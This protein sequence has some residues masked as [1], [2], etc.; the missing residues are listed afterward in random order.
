MSSLSPEHLNQLADLKEQLEGAQILQFPE[1]QPQETN[2]PV[3]LT[4]RSR[5]VGRD[6]G[7]P[8]QQSVDP[9]MAAPS[10]VDVVL[11]ESAKPAVSTRVRGGAHRP[12]GAPEPSTP[13]QKPKS[14][15]ALALNDLLTVDRL[16]RGHRPD[17]TMLSKYER[18]Q[19]M[20]HEV[21]I[22]RGLG[23]L[24]AERGLVELD[25]NNRAHR[26]NGQ[27]MSNKELS[28]LVSATKYDRAGEEAAAALDDEPVSDDQ[29]SDRLADVATRADQAPVDPGAEADPARELTE[30]VDTLTE[31]SLRQRMKRIWAKG[32]DALLKTYVDVE[33]RIM[34]P[35]KHQE[36]NETQLRHRRWVLN[37]GIGALVV[38]R[39]WALQNGL[40]TGGNTTPTGHGNDLANLLMHGQDS[41]SGQATGLT[42]HGAGHLHGT[43]NGLTGH[44][45]HGTMPGEGL[46]GHAEPS[47]GRALKE[48]HTIWS[49]LADQAARHGHHLSD[50]QLDHLVGQTLQANNLSWEDAR[51]LSAGFHYSVPPHVAEAL[52][53]LDDD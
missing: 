46:T 19:I 40:H 15:G 18:S 43:I 42:G 25:E 44:G 52:N 39:V 3:S 31:P 10:E 16:G 26:A 13:E 32:R 37:A 27:L 8:E 48:G 38:Y 12:Q 6:Q 24:A 34:A 29:L 51:H 7:A 11:P 17:G 23:E 5:Q 4:V 28:Q 47:G 53:Q 50:K 1:R 36:L 20:A 2:K 33:N 45:H 14:T 41:Q 21:Q 30:P 49:D 35:R 22:R 9:V